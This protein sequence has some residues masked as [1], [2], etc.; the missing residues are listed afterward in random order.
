MDSNLRS[1]TWHDK[2]TNRRGEKLEEFLI[3]KQLFIMNED[4]E[5]KTFQSNRG[6]SNIDL[7][8]SNNKLLK[9]VQEWKIS[10]EESCSDHK[11]I[12]FCIGQ[13]N[14]RQTGNNIQCIKY[15]IREENYKKFEAL[16]TQ[17]MA[18]QMCGPRWGEDNRALDKYISSRIDNIEDMEDTVSKFSA[19]LTAACDKSFTK[20]RRFMKTHKH[21]TVPWWTEDLTINKEMSTR[22]QKE[23]PK[24]DKQ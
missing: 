6:S 3:S 12:Q 2:L 21:K 5:M 7:T 14:V 23:I 13:H 19:A 1:R 16:I 18:Q 10:E 15:I 9:E 24:D 17:E 20:A 22:V 4:S 8:I 11:I